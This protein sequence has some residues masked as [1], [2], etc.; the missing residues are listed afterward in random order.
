[1][2]HTFNVPDMSCGHCK[3]HIENALE[4]WGKA[5]KWTVDLEAK[6]VIVESGEKSEAVARVITDVG[7]SPSLA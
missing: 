6:K 2:T 7:Y 1:M 3:V 5:V 4:E